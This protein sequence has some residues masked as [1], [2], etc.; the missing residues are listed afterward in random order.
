[1]IAPPLEVVLSEHYSEEGIS[2]DYH[3]P[4]LRVLTFN[5]L[6]ATQ[7]SIPRPFRQVKGREPQAADVSEFVAKPTTTWP[8]K[9]SNHASSPPQV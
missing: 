9:A 4:Q 2:A 7:A 3:A 6:P 8:P 5:D 1:M